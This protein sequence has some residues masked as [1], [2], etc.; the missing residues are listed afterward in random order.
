MRRK[1]EDALYWMVIG[2]VIVPPALEYIRDL[3]VDYGLGWFIN[4]GWFFY[5]LLPFYM[6]YYHDSRS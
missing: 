4:V 3:L 2:F 5:L 6:M 1:F